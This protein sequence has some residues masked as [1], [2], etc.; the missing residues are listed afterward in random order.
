MGCRGAVIPPAGFP[1]SGK[2]AETPLFSNRWKNRT[3]AG[4]AVAAERHAFGIG[5]IKPFGD[6]RTFFPGAAHSRLPPP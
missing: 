2:Q 4:D 1:E 6:G 3:H 5:P